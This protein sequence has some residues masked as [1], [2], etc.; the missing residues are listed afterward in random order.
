MQKKI[1]LVILSL[2]L[3]GNISPARA[4]AG[5]VSIQLIDHQAKETSNIIDGNTVQLFAKLPAPV[6]AYS[7]VDFFVDGNSER[8]ATC[9]INSGGDSCKTDF[10][11]ALGWY[12]DINETQESQ[13]TIHVEVAGQSV[14]GTFVVTVKPRPVVM[15][16]GFISNWETWKSYLGDSGYLASLGLQGFAVGDGQAPGVL[17]TGK[18]SDPQARTNTIAQNAEV[19][20]QYIA[21]VQAKTGAEKV[22]LLVHSMGGM[23]A[24]Y[25]LD[26]VMTNENVAQIIFLGTPMSGSACVFPLAALGFMLP[27]SLEIQPSYMVNVFNN[28][29]IH[30]HGVPFHMMAG[31]FLTDQVA[32]PCA[33]APSDSVVGRDSATSIELDNEDDLPVYHGDL[34]TDSGVF[35]RGVRPFLELPPG[36]FEQRPDPDSSSALVI[37]PEQFSR[38]YTGHLAPGQT[39]QITIHIDPNVQL[40]N[41]SLYDSSR[42][43]QMDV[44]GANGNLIQLDAQKN[45]ILKLDDPDTMLYLGYGFAQPK[46]GAWVVELKTTSQT[47][48]AGADY[49]ISAR[50]LGGA[51]L[52]A[53]A[54]QTI[55]NLGKPV[56]IK[57]T[58]TRNGGTITPQSA[59]ALIR[60]PDG[61]T[62][63]V[64]FSAKGK[65]FNLTYQPTLIG[66]Y[67][68][69]LSVTGK[70]ANGA[71][72]ERAAYISF[73]T[74]SVEEQVRRAANSWSTIVLI[75]LLTVALIL[76]SIIKRKLKKLQNPTI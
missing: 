61:G 29:I 51:R 32:S 27:A 69:E 35:E 63:S 14:D 50:F 75:A 41:F 16:H 1:A 2:L 59:T 9:A 71:I 40:A 56:T 38:A 73:Q 12:W 44:H 68:V 48:T 64:E 3:I 17:N 30:R 18:A 33:D 76:V 5:Q 47:P 67:N 11:A 54:S 46:P 24:R 4:Q 60:K 22:D 43:L 66:L 15:V 72:I 52:E 8:V 57:G 53:R 62:E 58:L 39:A 6:D 13:R 37:T 49:A 20:S 55:F 42:S 70:M 23:I 21:G 25:Y 28:Q 26:R 74:Q 36:S 34:T 10:F 7:D 19:L 31:T 65:E 45:G